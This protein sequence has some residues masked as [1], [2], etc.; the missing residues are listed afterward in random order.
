MLTLFDTNI[1][2]ESIYIIKIVLIFSLHC[3]YMVGVIVYV[4]VVARRRVVGFNFEAAVTAAAAHR[5][6]H[7][8][9]LEIAYHLCGCRC[10]R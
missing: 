7:H 10:R 1:G 3:I 5:S 6:S 4:V 9:T 8:L 2:I